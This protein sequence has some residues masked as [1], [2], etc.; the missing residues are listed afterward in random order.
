MATV[1]GGRAGNASL[2][3]ERVVVSDTR[4]LGGVPG[5][6]AGDA[7]RRLNVEHAATRH[8]RS[9]MARCR[10]V[11]TDVTGAALAPMTK[12]VCAVSCGSS[13]TSSS[14]VGSSMRVTMAGG[15]LMMRESAITVALRPAN[16]RPGESVAA[17]STSTK[18]TSSQTA[19]GQTTLTQSTLGRTNSRVV[20]AVPGSTSASDI[21]VLVVGVT[22][23]VTCSNV[24][25]TS[26]TWPS[27][28]VVAG[29]RRSGARKARLLVVHILAG[30]NTRAPGAGGE[31]IVDGTTC[32]MGLGAALRAVVIWAAGARDSVVYA[33]TYGLV[34]VQGV[35]VASTSRRLVVAETVTVGGPVRQRGNVP[36]CT[37]G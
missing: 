9:V 33:S 20:V 18:A 5:V 13:N 17:Q 7:S 11:G 31:G 37:S 36:P 34:A 24:A 8:T 14:Q 3:A 21:T 35:V 32:Q 15:L 28:T 16:A 26:Q 29:S 1:V 19:L 25:S 2:R 23:A 30:W 12:L 27:G 22:A 10:V 4:G 6:R